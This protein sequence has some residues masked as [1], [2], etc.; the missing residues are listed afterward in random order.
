MMMILDKLLS[1]ESE[2][3]SNI[4]REH[5]RLICIKTI[6]VLLGQIDFDVEVVQLDNLEKLTNLIISLKGRALNKEECELLERII[7]Q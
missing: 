3:K 1:I 4:Y 2:V 5:S 6:Q 7:Q